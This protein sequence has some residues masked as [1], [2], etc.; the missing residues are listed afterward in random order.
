MLIEE[1]HLSKAWAN[2]L[3]H[4]R[5]TTDQTALLGYVRLIRLDIRMTANHIH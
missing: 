2:S 3:P 1:P 5:D 4:A